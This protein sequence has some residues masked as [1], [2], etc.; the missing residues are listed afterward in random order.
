MSTSKCQAGVK[1][2]L[3]C[4]EFDMGRLAVPQDK[5]LSSLLD[6]CFSA[7]T[8]IY[9]LD[10]PHKV[11]SDPSSLERM[12]CSTFDTA[13]RAFV[14][15][16]SPQVLAG[17]DDHDK[18]C[19]FV[20]AVAGI[21]MIFERLSATDQALSSSVFLRELQLFA[22]S[23]QRGH[24]LEKIEASSLLN[25]CYTT[26]VMTDFVMAAIEDRETRHFEDLPLGRLGEDLL[27][28]SVAWVSDRPCKTNGLPWGFTIMALN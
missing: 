6:R 14:T 5:T 12:L 10:D 27:S 1:A 4:L 22:E 9:S 21:G 15:E 2:S 20:Q 23:D 8:T 28:D 18:S 24:M 7:F 3:N 26:S 19:L 16:T 11:L 17:L 13:S 25:S